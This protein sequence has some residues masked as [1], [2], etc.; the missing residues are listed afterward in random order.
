[1]E[2]G[3]RVILVEEIPGCSALL[4]QALKDADYQVVATIAADEDLQIHAGRIQPDVIV[5]Q[6]G[7]PD[8]D[9]LARICS[10]S[11]TRPVVMFTQDEDS[12]KI[13]TAVEAG[14]SA[15]IVRGLSSDRVKPIID[16]A[17]ARFEKSRALHKELGQVR[18]ILAERKIIE[19][20]KGILMQQRGCSED[21]AYQVLRKSAMDRNRRIVE[22]AKNIIDVGELFD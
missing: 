7:S 16:V 6:I 14:I 13:R 5:I 15:Y 8:R 1:M 18:T 2:S 12:E 4:E 22:V 19:R 3:L 17:V 9:A 20:A 21:E 10:I 11:R